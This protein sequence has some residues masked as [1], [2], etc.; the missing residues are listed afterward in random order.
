MST[1]T[2]IYELNFAAPWGGCSVVVD[3]AEAVEYS[4]DPDA[5]AARHLGFANSEQ[6]REWVATD[7]TALCSERT[8]AGRMCRNSVGGHGQLDPAEWIVLHRSRACRMHGEP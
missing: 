3:R 6:Y 2:A 1:P 8:R 4:R 5:Y 7:G